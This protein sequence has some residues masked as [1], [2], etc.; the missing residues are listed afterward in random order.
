MTRSWC[1]RLVAVSVVAAMGA[2]GCSWLLV[3]PLPPDFQLGDEVDCTAD[4]TAPVIDTI[5]AGLHVASSVYLAGKSNDQNKNQVNTLITS[6]LLGLIVWGS[7]AIYGYRK[8]DAC[9]E[10]RADASE[11]YSHHLGVRH[12]AYGPPSPAAPPPGV[13][14]AGAAPAPEAAPVVTPNQASSPQQQDDERPTTH[15]AP[16]T[17]PWT[18][19]QDD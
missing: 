3:K 4:P 16:V 11:S 6:D 15:S 7:S 19:P 13:A 17:K 10:A 2:G 5:F 18:L 9:R 1:A 12:R 14:P 8:I